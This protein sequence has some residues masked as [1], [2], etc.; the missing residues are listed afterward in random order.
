ME[1]NVSNIDIH[2]NLLGLL[3]AAMMTPC[4]ICRR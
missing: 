3:S 1:Q 2:D 4:E